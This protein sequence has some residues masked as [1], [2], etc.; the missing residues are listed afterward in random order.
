MLPLPTAGGAPDSAEGVD[1][2]PQPP[3]AWPG[4]PEH[5]RVQTA[6]C[7]PGIRTE[8]QAF[9]YLL[10]EYQSLEDFPPQRAALK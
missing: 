6:S 3:A 5:G 9:A 7:S 4:L 1:K 10:Q 8:E 2:V